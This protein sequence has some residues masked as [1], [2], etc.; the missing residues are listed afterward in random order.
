MSD[1]GP[2][3]VLPE[4]ALGRAMQ[5]R[6]LHGWRRHVREVI[7]C[8]EIAWPE[9]RLAV[10]VESAWLDGHPARRGARRK[11]RAHRDR[12]ATANRRW[13]DRIDHALTR[14]GWAVLRLWDSEIEAD[15]DGCVDKIEAMLRAMTPTDMAP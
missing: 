1:S 5:A 9:A 3:S 15:L 4:Q 12:R 13:A 14:A 6:G 11:G 10:F 7:G 2:A 8:P